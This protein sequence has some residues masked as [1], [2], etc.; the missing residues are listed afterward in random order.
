MLKVPSA[1]GGSCGVRAG[2]MAFA[3]S[4]AA[5]DTEMADSGRCAKEKL[6]WGCNF[7]ELDICAFDR[8]AIV[9]EAGVL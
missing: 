7:A 4:R 9:D 6:P 2:L 1:R 8:E 3:N 5:K